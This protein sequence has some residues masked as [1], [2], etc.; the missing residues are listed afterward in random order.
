M[1]A[2]IAPRDIAG[3]PGNRIGDVV[4]IPTEGRIARLAVLLSATTVGAIVAD[5]SRGPT[6]RATKNL[7]LLGG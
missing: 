3:A 1:G 2:A 6:Q 4:V 5:R 7:H